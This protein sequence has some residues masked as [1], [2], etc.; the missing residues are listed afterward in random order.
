MPKISLSRLLRRNPRLRPPLFFVNR[1]IQKSGKLSFGSS[2]VILHSMRKR[3]GTLTPS[4]SLLYPLRRFKRIN[5]CAF[6]MAAVFF[7]RKG[8]FFAHGPSPRV[9]RTL[10][11]EHSPR[12]IPVWPKNCRYR[13]SAQVL[14]EPSQRVQLRSFS[15]LDGS[16]GTISVW[17]RKMPPPE[18]CTGLFEP[19]QELEYSKRHSEKVSN[20]SY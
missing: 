18:G 1:W 13:K 5:L 10:H 12:K 20:L 17:P 16:R 19:P 3:R 8:S 2:R 11:D 7:C 6:P 4:N 15:G 14:L 9:L